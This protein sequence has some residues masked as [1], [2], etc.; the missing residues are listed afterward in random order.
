MGPTFEK[1]RL[2]YSVTTHRDGVD[3]PPLQENGIGDRPGGD[4]AM[5]VHGRRATGVDTT[6]PKLETWAIDVAGWDGRELTTDGHAVQLSYDDYVQ[7]IVGAAGLMAR[8]L[9]PRD[10]R[11]RLLHEFT[12]LY[13]ELVAEH[14]DLESVPDID[15]MNGPG[16]NRAH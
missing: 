5:V 15:E 10:A 2:T 4:V 16:K 8:K 11:A 14:F 3:D 1:N 7:L 13:Y 6:D 12:K 9:D